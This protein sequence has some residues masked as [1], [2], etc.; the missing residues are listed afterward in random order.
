ME[1]G[2][3]P[4]AGREELPGRHI[5]I[6]QV[7]AWNMGWFRRAAG[8][9]QAALGERLGWSDKNVSA[10]ERSFESGRVREFDAQTLAGLA[11]ALGV[12]LLALLL[13]PDD[14]GVK[15]RFLWRARDGAP[16]QDMA[17][18]MSLAMPDSD[19][20]TPVMAAYRQ[21]LT[22]NV[23]RYLDPSWREAVELWLTDLATPEIRAQR[24]R[25]LREQRQVLLGLAADL[26]GMADAIDPAE[27]P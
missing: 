20:D 25:R 7:A 17:A 15:E 11:Q 10:A 2:S 14:D 27:D 21:R 23:A 16:G 1:N 5:T 22:D 9:S 12:P 26:D 6:N 8:L 18:L 19:D 4:S 3:E 13:P 24:A